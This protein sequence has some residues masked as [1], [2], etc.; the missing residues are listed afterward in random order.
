M[1]ATIGSPLVGWRR[2]LARQRE[3]LQRLLQRH[4]VGLQAAGG[5]DERFGFSPSPCC[6]YS[7]K[8]PLRSVISSP[9]SGTWPST[10]T[11]GRSPSPLSAPVG[12]STR[13]YFA[14]GI[15]CAANRH[16]ELAELQRKLPLAADRAEGA[17]RR[18][19]Q[20]RERCPARKGR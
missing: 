1:P 20:G 8:R 11:P 16:D 5:S 7:P 17:D 4:V 19:R 6:T 12:D 3:E 18:R 14:L 9:G 10:V 13:V 15:V 2:D